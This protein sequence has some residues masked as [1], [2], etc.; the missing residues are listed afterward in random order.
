[1]INRYF[2][3]L[4]KEQ[5]IKIKIERI[6]LDSTSIEADPKGTGIW[7]AMNAVKPLGLKNCVGG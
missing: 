2:I 3:V 6:S 7:E 4:Q 1:M 5:I